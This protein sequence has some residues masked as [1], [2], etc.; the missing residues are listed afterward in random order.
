MGPPFPCD[1]RLQRA[2]Q[3]KTLAW[4]KRTPQHESKR[5]A[6][7]FASRG[8]RSD[9]GRAI[10]VRHITYRYQCAAWRESAAAGDPLPAATSA[11]EAPSP[12]NCPL[13]ACIPARRCACAAAP[14]GQPRKWPA[15]TDLEGGCRLLVGP[16]AQSRARDRRFL[17]CLA[18]ATTSRLT[19]PDCPVSMLARSRPI[20]IDF[21]SNPPPSCA[22]ML[23]ESHSLAVWEGDKTSSRS[24][25]QM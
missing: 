25:P 12:V 3:T 24:S 4:F 13:R 19:L 18:G 14:T 11:V 5:L 10:T 20:S 2:F 17:L 1:A 23:L 9:N 16:L 15:E 22:S 21:S 6:A 7:S 8:G